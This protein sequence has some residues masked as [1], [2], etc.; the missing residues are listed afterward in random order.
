MLPKKSTRGMRLL[1]FT[2][3]LSDNALPDAT[4]D[5][6]SSHQAIGTDL[7]ADVALPQST[8]AALHHA[9]I[10]LQGDKYFLSKHQ[11][12]QVFVKIVRSCIVPSGTQLQVGQQHIQVHANTT[13]TQLLQDKEGTYFYPS[14]HNQVFMILQ[15]LLENGTKG[16]AYACSQKKIILGK[17]QAD[18]CFPQDLLVSSPHAQIEALSDGRFIIEDA[19]SQQGT[20]VQIT[21]PWQLQEGDIF[22]IGTCWIKTES[23]DL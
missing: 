1:I 16:F 22:R 3:C 13:S 9:H 10:S 23:M 11:E 4:Y 17:Q 7:Q 6:T 2:E 21:K 18:V 20:F 8:K 15:Q 19:E 5:V 14:A 12:N